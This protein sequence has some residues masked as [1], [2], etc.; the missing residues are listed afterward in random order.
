MW[1]SSRL[2]NT[3]ARHQKSLFSLSDLHCV[4]SLVTNSYQSAYKLF[5]LCTESSHSEDKMFEGQTGWRTAAAAERD[6]SSND[7]I[8]LCCF[9]SPCHFW[10]GALH[11]PLWDGYVYEKHFF[12]CISTIFMLVFTVHQWLSDICCE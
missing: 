8:F 9:L 7:K 4:T 1:K 11:K 2:R 10:F 6:S 12:P 3:F 5:C